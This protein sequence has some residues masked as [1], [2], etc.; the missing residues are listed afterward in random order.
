MTLFGCQSNTGVLFTTVDTTKTCI[1]QGSGAGWAAMGTTTTAANGSY[2]FTGLRM[3]YYYVGVTFGL[4]GGAVQ[5]AEPIYN[6]TG[7]TCGTTNATCAGNWNPTGAATTVHN[8][9]LST[10]NFNPIGNNNPLTTPNEDIINVNF[11]YRSVPARIFGKVFTDS[12]GDGFQTTGEAVLSGVTVRLCADPACNTVILT[13]ATN[14]TGQYSFTGF[15]TPGT[16]YVVVTQP[17]S[18]IQTADPDQSGTC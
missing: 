7:L 13:T 4:P 3:G 1:G 16:Y 14:S 9:N 12:N 2:T 5:S 6:G 18:T 10:T 15:T 8:T 11:G 17:G